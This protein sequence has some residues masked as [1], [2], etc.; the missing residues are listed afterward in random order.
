MPR[1][2]ACNNASDPAQIDVGCATVSIDHFAPI[3]LAAPINT[4]DY[5]VKFPIDNSYDTPLCFILRPP[6]ARLADS[7]ATL[8][9]RP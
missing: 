2:P 3:P 6:F 8:A 9:I 5:S 1:R 4:I 7:L